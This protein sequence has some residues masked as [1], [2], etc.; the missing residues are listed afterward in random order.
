MGQR[1]RTRRAFPRFLVDSASEGTVVSEAGFAPRAWRGWIP[2]KQLAV[3]FAYSLVN[4]SAGNGLLPLLPKYAAQLGALEWQIGLYLGSSYA[5]IAAGTVVAGWL[6][7][8]VGHRRLLMIL[9]GL[10]IPPLLVG[11]SQ[12]TAFWEAVVLTAAIWWL[13]GMA[14]SFASILAGLSAG[15]RERGQVLGFLAVAAPAG[16]VIG[17]LGIG[18]LA[19]AVGFSRM[20]LVLAG[21]YLLCPASALLV[22]DIPLARKT[23]PRPTAGPHG[24]W[25]AAFQILLGVSLLAAFGSFIGAL[26]RSLAMK[27]TFTNAEITSTV[28]VSGVVTL[29][30]PF[31]IGFL[32]DR[33]GRLRF[34]ALCYAAGAVGLVVYASAAVLLQFWVASA[35]VAFVSYVSTGVSSALVVDLVDRD[36][37]GRGLAL[38][39]ATGWAGGIL[40]F[41]AGGILFQSLGFGLAFLVGAALLAT[42]IVLLPAIA[43]AMRSAAPREGARPARFA[44]RKE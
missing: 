9:V 13:A 22:T 38:F 16:S 43:W 42:T 31:L 15:P 40:G 4:W 32:S 12:V 5:A 34:L 17:G 26:G 1:L 10:G 25:G 7:D 6:A 8:R 3:L 30:F 27:D 18:V 20:W 2:G 21:L 41:V 28:F 19:D 14:L 44:A 36:S 33:L 11:M 35:L 39:S 24:A 29:P 37:I 23:V